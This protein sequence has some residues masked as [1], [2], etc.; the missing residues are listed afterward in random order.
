MN[1]N[2]TLK[3]ETIINRIYLI[4]GEKV[5]LDK[6]LAD[7]YQ[8]KPIR[9]REQVKRNIDRF[10]QHFM[11][12]LNKKETSDLLSQNAIPSIQSL[13]GHTPYVFSE[14]GILQLANVL[15]ST[16]ANLMSIRIIEIFIKM[17]EMLTNHK[18]LLLKIEMLENNVHKQ[19]TQIQQ[20]TDDI[21][22]VF[23]ALKALLKTDPEPR[24][25]IGFKPD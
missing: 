5:M 1:E 25:R 20:N 13:G 15:R 11:F 2:V 19:N 23:D 22:L 9:L 12:Q 18:D 24:K 21:Q 17:R 7:L 3:E 4:R 8:V 14:F 6:D 10:P 16:Q